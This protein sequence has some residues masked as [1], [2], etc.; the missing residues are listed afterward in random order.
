MSDVITE[1]DILES[2]DVRNVR[3]DRVTAIDKVGTLVV[4]PD[5]V[6]ATTEA[7]AAFY[8]VSV[9]AIKS[10]VGRHRNELAESGR[11]VAQ[12]S[13][14]RELRN[15]AHEID[16]DTRSLALFTRRAVLN[17]GMLL[18]DSEVAKQVR[19]YLLE[20]EQLASP[21][22]KKTA[23]Q[24]LLEKVECRAFRDLIAENAC[25]YA[26]N[27]KSTSRAFAEAQNLLYQRITG[28]T[29]KQILGCRHDIQAWD[30]KNGPTKGDRKVAKNYL[31]E[32]ELQRLTKFET[33]LM[34][35]AEVMFGDG[36]TLTMDQ[37]LNLIRAESSQVA[38]HPPQP[39]APGR[40]PS[41]PQGS[42]RP[43]TTSGRRS[44]SRQRK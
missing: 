38:V 15:E 1:T 28:L 27:D 43:G 18:R 33:L 2:R 23:Y 9:K 25:D 17:V 40:G 39:V 5:D 21:D 24:R 4:L 13:D 26:P 11:W 35:K 37:W 31:T 20:V 29:A 7:V 14:L 32:D 41:T 8:G 36:H 16:P 42:T 12:G 30:G 10:L 22:L 19:A 44:R 6:H 3:L 34:A